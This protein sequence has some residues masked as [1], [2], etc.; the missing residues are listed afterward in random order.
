MFRI[1]KGGIIVEAD[2]VEEVVALVKTL[3][4]EF[5][6]GYRSIRTQVSKGVRTCQ[7]R[8]F[9]KLHGPSRYVEILRGT[10]I[11]AGSLPRVLHN[12][13]IQN[14]EGLW[15]IREGEVNGQR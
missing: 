6:A 2:S 8:D 4:S 1:Q 11:P 7:V 15:T 12:D 10:C 14:Q 13:F 3:D 9:L 5:V